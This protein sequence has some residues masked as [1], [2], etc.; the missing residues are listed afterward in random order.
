M[1]YAKGT[2]AKMVTSGHTSTPPTPTTKSLEGHKKG[3]VVRVKLC[4]FPPIFVARVDLEIDYTCL[5]LLYVVAFKITSSIS[6]SSHKIDY[7]N[8]Y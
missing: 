7:P 8:N 2:S 5:S 6:R 1:I 4:F 3:T